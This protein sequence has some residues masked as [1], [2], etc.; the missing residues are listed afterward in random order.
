MLSIGLRE[1]FIPES[2]WLFEISIGMSVSES[3]GCARDWSFMPSVSLVFFRTVQGVRLVI[4]VG[5]M[6]NGY[7]SSTISRVVSNSSSVGAVDWNLLVVFT[8][9]ISVSIGIREKSSLE[10]FVGR[11]LNTR[12]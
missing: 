5:A 9:S 8:Q 1:Y 4:R 10:H 6:S 7:V 11:R 12:N 3:T 2:S